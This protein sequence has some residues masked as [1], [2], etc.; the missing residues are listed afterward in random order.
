MIFHM[1]FYMEVKH[2]LYNSFFI[3]NLDTYKLCLISNSPK[4]TVVSFEFFTLKESGHILNLA[5]TGIIYDH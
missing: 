4:E 1:M 5:R 2:H 3:F